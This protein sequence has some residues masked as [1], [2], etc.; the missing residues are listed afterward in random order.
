MA[1]KRKINPIVTDDDFDY[2]YLLE[3]AQDEENISYPTKSTYDADDDFDDDF[4]C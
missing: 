1:K 4:W 3:N 2:E